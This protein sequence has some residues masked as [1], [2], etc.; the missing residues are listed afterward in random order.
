MMQCFPS[1][2]QRKFS[3]A[4]VT[5]AYRSGKTLVGA[6]IN[7]FK[8]FEHIDEPW[9]PWM[10]PALQ[11]YGLVLPDSARDIL[12]SYTEELFYELILLRQGNLRVNDD[13][14]VWRSKSPDEIFYRLNHLSTKRDVEAYIQ[15]KNYT[16]LYNLGGMLP[17]LDFMHQTF[18]EL[19]SVIMIRNPFSVAELIAKKGWFSNI[20]LES[21]FDTHLYQKYFWQKQAK[22]MYIPWWVDQDDFDEFLYLDDYSRGIYFWTKMYSMRIDESFG[23]EAVGKKLLLKYEDLTHHKKESLN[24]LLDFF[25]AT[26]TTMTDKVLA[27]LSLKKGSQAE[28]YTLPKKLNNIFLDLLEKFHYS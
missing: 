16:L 23:S 21:P 1:N 20:A 3:V 11:H 18:S 17:F 24:I 25:E 13:S 10:L 19:K 26:G 5:G 6:L 12:K 14:S 27:E 4:L 7:T 15:N 8:A 22:E 2:K 9:L 28:R